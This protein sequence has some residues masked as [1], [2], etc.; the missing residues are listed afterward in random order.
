[1][2]FKMMEKEIYNIA[3]NDIER[4]LNLRK[5]KSGHRLIEN[6]R[7]KIVVLKMSDSCTDSDKVQQS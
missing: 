1:M 2:D 7:L 3:K 6:Y 5:I 4:A